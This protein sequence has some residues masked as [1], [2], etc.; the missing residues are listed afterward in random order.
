MKEPPMI[1]VQISDPHVSVP[2]S[3][4]DRRYRSAER[5]QAAVDRIN[6]FQPRPDAVV[7]T[8]DLVDDVTPDEYHRLAG[9]LAGLEIR[10]HLLLGNHDSADMLR[11]AMPGHTYLPT[12]PDI[13]Y[14]IDDLPVRLIMLDTNIPKRPEGELTA[15]RLEWLDCQLTAAPD[16]PTMIFM[17]HPPIITGLKAMDMMGLVRGRDELASLMSRHSQVL[18]ICCGH[19]HRP[20]SGT[21]GPVPVQTCPGVAHQID[22]DLQR[23]DWVG[24][25]QEPP[26]MLVHTY[27]TAAGLVTHQAVIDTFPAYPDNRS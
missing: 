14:V 2:G 17:H 24:L 3:I 19:L 18:R 4:P 6:G 8:G 9:I 27:A 21:C 1:L 5:L 23:D 26:S 25:V 12:G 22:L 7:I 15:E 13:Q 20:I 10:C 16:R 11:A